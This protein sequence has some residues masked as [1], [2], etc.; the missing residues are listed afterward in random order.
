MGA[1]KSRSNCPYIGIDGWSNSGDSDNTTR[2]L[3]H[4]K[5]PP[6]S[7]GPCVLT[8]PSDG[9]DIFRLGT[10]TPTY[11]Q[12]RSKGPLCTRVP[13]QW[14]LLSRQG[15]W[16]KTRRYHQSSL[17]AFTLSHTINITSN[18]YVKLPFLLQPSLNLSTAYLNL[19]R[20]HHVH[21]I[22]ACRRGSTVGSGT[23]SGCKPQPHSSP[24]NATIF[25]STL[26][27][28]PQP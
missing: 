17:T 6:S 2:G 14:R 1:G 20:H 3:W 13:L 24:S 27:S 4:L 10:E 8:V 16:H 15:L 19:Q 18:R 7:A 9:R 26:N 5:A 22:H 11:Y 21:R 25:I 12:P 28:S 23:R